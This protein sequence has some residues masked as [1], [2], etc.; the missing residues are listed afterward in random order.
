MNW[1]WPDSA[2]FLSP[3]ATAKF[4]LPPDGDTIHPPPVTKSD[5]AH[6]GC[7]GGPGQVMSACADAMTTSATP[8]TITCSA[9]TVMSPGPLLFCSLMITSPPPGSITV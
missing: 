9:L 8:G 4:A 5:P 1:R 2:P 6:G 7:G 3:P